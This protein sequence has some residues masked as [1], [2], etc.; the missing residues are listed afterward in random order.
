MAEERQAPPPEPVVL[1]DVA[2][3]PHPQA[4]SSESKPA[5]PTTQGSDAV[6]R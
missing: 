6:S 4:E 2:T 3:Q 1:P 5:E